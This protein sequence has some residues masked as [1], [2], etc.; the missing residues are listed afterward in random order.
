MTL[1]MRVLAMTV[2]TLALATAACGTMRKGDS[3]PASA[4]YDGW[5]TPPLNHTAAPFWGISVAGGGSG[6]QEPGR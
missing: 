6:V 5:G 1:K 4:M 2:A 3:G